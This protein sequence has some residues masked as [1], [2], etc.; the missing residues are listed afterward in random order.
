MARAL[1]SPNPQ[2]L[3]RDSGG[4]ARGIRTRRGRPGKTEHV[5]WRRLIHLGWN[6]NTV[7]AEALACAE[8]TADGNVAVLLAFMV[9]GFPVNTSG[10]RVFLSRDRVNQESFQDLSAALLHACLMG[11]PQ[12]TFGRLGKMNTASRQLDPSFVRHIHNQPI[13]F[14]SSVPQHCR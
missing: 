13:R 8:V 7:G 6:V 12:E 9:H 14:V 1:G 11:D 3:L 2:P 4:V 10:R 5:V